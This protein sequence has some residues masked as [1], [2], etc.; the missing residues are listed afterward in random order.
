MNAISRILVP[1]DFSD[2]SRS[3]LTLAVG[4]ASRFGAEVDVFHVFELPPPYVPNIMLQG[5]GG[6]SGT[7]HQVMRREAK[8]E[9]AEFLRE[10]VTAEKA[11]A[12]EVRGYTR[13]GEPVEAII[14]R[15]TIG[16]Y[17]LVVMGT[18]GRS[19]LSRMFMGSV[20]E[21]VVR[22]APGPVLTFRRGVGGAGTD[23]AAAA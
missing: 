12:L 5:Q 20:A 7:V 8:E 6:P 16:H 14:R 23:E 18:R 15:A 17:D 10:A 21:A 3:A 4:L 1:V 2:W 9:L 22:G 13:C 11:G 19:G